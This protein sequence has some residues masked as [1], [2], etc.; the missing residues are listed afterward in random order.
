M[1]VVWSRT[2]VSSDGTCWKHHMP[3]I[4]KEGWRVLAVKQTV[5]LVRALTAFG[6][7]WVCCLLCFF[8]N[9]SKPM[10]TLVVTTNSCVAAEAMGWLFNLQ[11]L[12]HFA[13][14]EESSIGGLKQMSKMGS[15]MQRAFSNRCSQY[16][17]PF[18]L[19]IHVTYKSLARASAS[20]FPHCW[21]AAQ[22]GLCS[23]SCKVALNSCCETVPV[24][25]LSQRVFSACLTNG[26]VSPIQSA[27][28][29][30]DTFRFY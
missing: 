6:F 15:D 2:Q 14:S 17:F 4:I 19:G 20:H 7:T 5:L 26:W 22:P 21:R 28:Q 1:K 29:C 24:L 27:K 18:P 11:S 23:G 9:I 25:L 16:L 8:W 12:S 30:S 10:Q 3:A 13:L